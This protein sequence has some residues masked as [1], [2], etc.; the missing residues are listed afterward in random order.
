MW[1]GGKE[2]KMKLENLN[3][4]AKVAKGNMEV[5]FRMKGDS[6]YRSLCGVHVRC[7]KTSL[8]SMKDD[9]IISLTSKQNKEPVDDSF[10]VT[11]FDLQEAIRIY[12]KGGVE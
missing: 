9:L 10:Y 6:L 11:A 7:C 12:S 2:I 5:L 1:T 3:M 4:E 8:E